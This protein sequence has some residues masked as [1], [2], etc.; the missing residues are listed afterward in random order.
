MK[1]KNQKTGFNNTVRIFCGRSFASSG[2]CARRLLLTAKSLSACV[3]PNLAVSGVDGRKT[4]RSKPKIIGMIPSIKNIH[5]HASQPF[6]PFKS[7]WMPYEMRPLKALAREV[8][9]QKMPPRVASSGY[10][11]QNDRSAA[12]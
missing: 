10:V 2:L 6:L 11:Y 1:T 8:D 4:K 7:V 3:K 9:P 5:L 12:E